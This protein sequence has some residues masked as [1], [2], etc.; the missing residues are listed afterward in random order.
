MSPAEALEWNPNWSQMDRR[1][2]QE[3]L[4]RL[5]VVRCYVPPSRGYVG[6]ED[7]TGKRVMFLAPGYVE[8]KSDTA[9]E[10][11]EESRGWP[12]FALTTFRHRGSRTNFEVDD[13]QFC[14]VHGLQ[15]PRTGR[16]DD[17][18]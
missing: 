8:F 11:L 17:C 12:G 16:C 1:V 4:D 9:P 2:I 3:H 14:P 5:D 10:G 6:C 13:E 18:E 7:A 15:L